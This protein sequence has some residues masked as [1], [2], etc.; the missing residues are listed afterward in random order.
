MASAVDWTAAGYGVAGNDKPKIL[1]DAITE[2]VLESGANT[3]WVF[4]GAGDSSWPL[5]PTL[6]RKLAGASGRIPTEEDLRRSEKYLIKRG[7]DWQLDLTEAGPIP[8]M[9]L[10]ARMQHHGAPTR[11]LDVT[12]NPMT[13]LWFACSSHFECEGVLFLLNVTDLPT[14]RSIDWEGPSLNSWGAASDPLGFPWTYALESSATEKRPFLVNPTIRD[15]R[16]TAQEGLFLGSSVPGNDAQGPIQG[17]W[18]PSDQLQII[19]R[20]AWNFD[21]LGVMN[22]SGEIQDKLPGLTIIALLIP[23]SIKRDL[24]HVLDVTYTKRWETVFPDIAGFSRAVE[25]G[26]VPVDPI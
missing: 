7:R 11:L 4:R 15:Q 18:P 26:T 14:Y 9:H 24:L 1:L 5:S 13:A 10:L 3:R 21:K 20:M 6:Y 25:E 8:D 23:A 22:E 12:C 17:L 2:L 16:M 19:Q